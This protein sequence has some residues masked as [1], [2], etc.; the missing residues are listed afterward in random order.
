MNREKDLKMQLIEMC[1]KT[2]FQ[3]V[4]LTELVKNISA[5]EKIK[6]AAEKKEEYTGE[7]NTEYHSIKPV[8]DRAIKKMYAEIERREDLGM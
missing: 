4:G 7:T 6:I 3:E 2:D 1:E 5:M 8:L